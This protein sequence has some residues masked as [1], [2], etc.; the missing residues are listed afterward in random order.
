MGYKPL[1]YHFIPWRIKYSQSHIVFFFKHTEFYL[2]RF[3]KFCTFVFVEIRWPS[4]SCHISD[5]NSKQHVQRR[6]SLYLRPSV[7][8]GK[9]NSPSVNHWFDFLADVSLSDLTSTAAPL[10]YY[11]LLHSHGGNGKLFMASQIS[12]FGKWIV[13]AFL[14]ENRNNRHRKALSSK[15]ITDQR[16][17]L[18]RLIKVYAGSHVI[19]HVWVH[20]R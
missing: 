9:R 17:W 8:C 15:I 1:F 10:L 12:E 5:A 4:I 3:I 14:R 2:A 20:H 16:P 19:L 7:L 13:S 11:R 18:L 6:P